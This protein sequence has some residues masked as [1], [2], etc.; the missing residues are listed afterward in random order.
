MNFHWLRTMS[1]AALALLTL[2]A[3]VPI[4]PV[5][6]AQSDQPTE[7]TTYVLVHGAFQDSSAWSEVVPLLEAQGHNVVTLD[8]PGRAGDTTPPAEITLE[9]HRDAVIDLINQQ[10][11]KV[12]LVGHSFGGITISL[13]AEAIPDQIARLVYVA[14]YLPVTGDTLAS[15]AAQDEGTAFND[16]NFVIAPDYSTAS[17]LADD[18]VKIFCNDCTPDMQQ[19]TQEQILPEPLGPMNTPVTVSAENFGRVRKVYI[20]TLQDNAVSNQLQK[21]MLAATPV[22][23]VLTL[24]TGHSPFLSDP[25]GLVAA[26]TNLD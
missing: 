12:I 11:G 17:V 22:D 1:V 19:R 16:Q 20:E 25:A 23:K 9:Q 3:C 7:A 21:L 13:V 26:L 14:A 8:L 15:L 4:Q 18:V 10:S 5:P 2:V 6:A 24:E